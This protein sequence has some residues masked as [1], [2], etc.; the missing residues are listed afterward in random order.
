MSI[1]HFDVLIVGAG[2]SG[3]GAAYHLQTQCPTKRYAILEGRESMG[4]TWDLFRYP[5]IRSDSDM[6]TLG[7]PFHPWKEAKAIADG[8]AIL[9]YLR[10][11]AQTYGIDRHI[12][13]QHKVVRAD[14]SSTDAQWTVTVERG[15]ATTPATLTCNFFYLCS[16]YYRYDQGYMPGFPGQDAFKGTLIH[17]Q[18]WPETLDYTGKRVVIIGSG[19]TAVTLVPA[20]ADTAAHV[21]MLQRS[22][23]YVLSLPAVDPIANGLRKLLPEKTAHSVSRWK[24]VMLSILVYQLSMRRPALMKKLL[25][26]GVAAQLPRDFDVDTHFNPRYNP[27]QQR[28]CLVPNN[29]LFKSIRKGRASVVTDTIETFEA[30]GIRLKSGRKLEADIVVSATGLELLAMGGIQIGVDGRAIEPA[31]CFSYRGMMLSGVPNAAACIGYTNAS[32]TLRADLVSRWVCRL[33]NHMDRRGAAIV[34]P[35]VRDASMGELPLLDLTSGY[36]QRAAG[37]FPKQGAVA[38]WNLRQ[39]YVLERLTLGRGSLDDGALEYS[40]PA[41]GTA[42]PLDKAA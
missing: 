42:R 9:R 24:N 37:K 41:A 40:S 34:T 35:R 36:V 19:A 1:D 6:F 12:R 29:D 3:I 21:T 16:G 13:Y 25:R 38:P 27:W 23:S 22:P 8:P 10:E 17:P 15:P 5:G 32:W 39:N 2:I 28:L 31:E 14:W 7:F 30:D 20:M 33:I 4:G 26:K 18:K 11:T